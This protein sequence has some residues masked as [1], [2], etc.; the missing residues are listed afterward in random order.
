M[1]TQFHLLILFV[2][3]VASVSGYAQNAGRSDSVVVQ[4]SIV[5]CVE[6]QNL[7]AP[8]NR[9]YLT[10]GT[11]ISGG[12]SSEKCGYYS[13][14]IYVVR[15]NKKQVTVH[16][17]ISADSKS[18]EKELVLARGRRNEYQLGPDVK[19]IASY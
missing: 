9:S 15:R 7:N 19:V 6:T 4:I 11:G 5:N 18:I 13:Y 1:K 2:V 8:I 12:G 3:L 17:S 10:G 14:S 16:L